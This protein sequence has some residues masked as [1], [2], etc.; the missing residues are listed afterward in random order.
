MGVTFQWTISLG[1]VLSTVI[2]L[3]V[4]GVITHR[5]SLARHK[6]LALE[7]QILDLKVSILRLKKMLHLDEGEDG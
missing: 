5:Y 7:Q 2:F 3:V 1:Q 4:V 6:I